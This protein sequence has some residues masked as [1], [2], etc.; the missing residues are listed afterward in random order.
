VRHR[1]TAVLTLTACAVP[2]GAIS[3]LGVGEWIVDAPTSVL[4]E[5]GVRPDPIRSR[6][7]RVLPA[8][9]TVRWL[10]AGIDGDALDRAVGRRLGDRRPKTTGAVGLRGLAV[11]GKSLRGASK[12]KGRKIHLFAALEHTTGLVLAQLDV[13]RANPAKA[14]EAIEVAIGQIRNLTR[15]EAKFPFVR[16]E[17]RSYGFHRNLYGIRWTGRSS[18]FLVALG[19]LAYM[20]WLANFDHQPALTLVNVLSLLS[21]VVCLA[22]WWILPSAVRIESAAE[23]YAYELLQAAVVL[24]AEKAE[25]GS[26]SQ[27]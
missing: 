21:T 16:A 10:L 22:I 14:D 18:A 15:D 25:P 1:L 20:L 3:L 12:A 11:D 24:A 23:R 27:E 5:V 26:D 7:G 9:T 2:A 13:E 6:P 4:Q 17:N 19:V 8:G